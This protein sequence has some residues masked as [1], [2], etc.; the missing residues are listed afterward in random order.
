MRPGLAKEIVRNATAYVVAI[1]LLAGCAAPQMNTASGRP[2]VVIHADRT[3]TRAA[4]GPRTGEQAIPD[5]G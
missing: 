5:Y 3:K 4:P 2:E 1:A